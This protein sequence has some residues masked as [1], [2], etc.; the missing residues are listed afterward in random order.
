[1]IK[2]GLVSVTFRELTPREIIQLVVEAK[3]TAIEWGGDIHVPH[4]DIETARQVSELTLS[5]GID[6]ASY[7]SY[8]KVGASERDGLMFNQVLSTA[9][10]L[11]APVIRVWA[12]DKS[13]CIVD[14]EQKQYIVSMSREMAKKAQDSNVDLVFEFHSNTLTD[15]YDSTIELLEKIDMPNFLSYWQPVVQCSV[16]ENSRGLEMLLPWIRGVHCFNWLE[17]FTRLPLSDGFDEWSGYIN[18]LS[19]IERNIYS[20][21]EF[22][23]D[24]DSQNFIEDASTLNKW[25]PLVES[26][27]SS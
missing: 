25:F 15:T 21:I 14:S 7:G 18:I 8:Y 1:M 3:L 6:I 19:G 24:D 23:R 4:G 17:D 9:N 13:S 11:N 16:Q 12:G 20:M 2:P 5:N 22:V 10:A 27:L 26:V